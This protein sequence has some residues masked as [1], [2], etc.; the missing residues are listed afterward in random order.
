VENKSTNADVGLIFTAYS[1]RRLMKF[2]GIEVLKEC[3]LV[4]LFVLGSVLASLVLFWRTKSI[5]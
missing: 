2:A 4:Y 1:L 3:L 5:T